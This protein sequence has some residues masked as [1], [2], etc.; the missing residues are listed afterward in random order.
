MDAAVTRLQP[1]SCLISV[2][3]VA[4][5]TAEP[6]AGLL[7]GPAAAQDADDRDATLRAPRATGPTLPS[8]TNGRLQEEA[9]GS[10]GLA[11][12]EDGG[13]GIP[14]PARDPE[15]R[16]ADGSQPPANRPGQRRIIADGDLSYPREPSQPL[17]GVIDTGIEEPLTDGV[18]PT[19][20]DTRPQE[21]LDLFENPPAGYD[22][23]LFQIED[24]SPILDRRPR[25][26]FR[27]EPYDPVGIR[28]GSFVL[29]PEAETNFFGDTNILSSPSPESDVAFEFNPRLRAVS[30]WNVHALEFNASSTLSFFNEFDTED[31]RFY[32]LEARGRLDFTRRTNLQAIVSRG[33]A[34]EDRSAINA[35][36]LTERT[37]VTSDRAA[38]TLNHRFNRLSLRFRGGFNQTDYSDLTSGGVTFSNSERDR[39]EWEQAVRATWEFKP[40]LSV[41]SEAEFNQRDYGATAQADN[42]RRDSNGQRYRV[43]LDFGDTGQILRGE[44]SVGYGIQENEN[45]RLNDV[46][47]FL[48]D[49]NAAWRVSELTTLLL[50]GRTAFDENTAR[51][52]GGIV[53]HAF[54]LEARHAF[55]RHLIGSAGINYSTRGYDNQDLDEHEWQGSLGVEYFLNRNAIVFSNYLHTDFNSTSPGSSFTSDEFRVGLRVRR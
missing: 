36:N 25:R 17:D 49:A 38:A 8:R 42:I 13:D 47:A 40:T 11:I 31:D 53:T 6:W 43:G 1:L 20:F 41:F 22:P 34:Q 23:L 39:D 32:E 18:D 35:N 2:L 7:A 12:D 14:D 51:L 46:D 52:S 44:V 9:S 54:G 19:E 48:F 30:D 21:D 28:A 26:L 29:F 50:S 24:I 10:A 33:Y 5:A 15:Q 4:F 27:L 37:D 3:V 55:R 45:S 16:D